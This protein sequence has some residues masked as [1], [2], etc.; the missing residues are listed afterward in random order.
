M[1]IPVP[2]AALDA[3][4]AIPEFRRSYDERGMSIN[5]FDS[6]GAM[7]RTLRSFIEG[8]HAFVGMIRDVVLPNPDL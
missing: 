2:Q 1:H 8:T 7:V 3:L 6:Y 5:E 4:L